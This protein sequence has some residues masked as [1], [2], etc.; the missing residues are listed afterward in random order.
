M[1]KAGLIKKTIGITGCDGFIGK[2]LI[3]L[4]GK[5][6]KY[7]IRC[8]KGDLLKEEDV[9]DFFKKGDID[10]VIHLAGAFFGDFNTLLNVNFKTTENLVRIG[11]ENGMRK[12]IF[13]STGAVYGEP[14]NNASKESDPTK[15][16]TYYGITKLFAEK[17]IELY[18][19]LRGLEYVILRFPNVYGEGNDK[20]VIFNF[21]RDIKEKG[22]ITVYGDGSATRDFLHVS[23]A[24]RA[25]IKSINYKGSEIFNISNPT[26]ISISGLVLLL[27]KKH[28]FSVDY[29]EANN[30]LKSLHLSV[31]KASDFLGFRTKVSKLEIYPF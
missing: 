6:G 31:K 12:I 4:I 20:G 30:N 16:N 21:L 22:A 28:T 27:G 1:G 24:C 26:K 8:F 25:I 5:S 17:I 14:V 19:Y 13:S 10:M 23:D 7:D 2:H 29:R 9:K 3:E 15:P 11:T 18:S